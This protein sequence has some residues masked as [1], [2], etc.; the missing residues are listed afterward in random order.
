RSGRSDGAPRPAPGRSLPGG[1]GRGLPGSPPRARRPGSPGSPP[2][3]AAPGSAPPPRSPERPSAAARPPVPEPAS[4]RRC[5]YQLLAAA[6]AEVDHALIGQAA[7][8]GHDLLLRRLD[9]GQAYRAAGLHVLQQ[10]LGRTLGHVAGDLLAHPD[11]GAAQGDA[12]ALAGDLAQQGLQLA[13][14]QLDQVVEHEH[15]V[16][17]AL[18]QF[19]V[20]LAD[21]AQDRLVLP[22]LQEVEDV[23]RDLDA[24]D[25]G[26]LEVLVAG[27]LALH[28]LVE[29]V[30]RVRR[31]AVEG[32]D[33]Q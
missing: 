15:Q 9:V 23:R 6:V 7:D 20:D 2:G 13:V 5:S 30:Q 8:D 3:W 32:G 16:L 33:A 28:D 1:P 24:A 4:G 27:E 22:G 12:Q 18:A 31:D 14:V 19:A 11:V 29:L 17:D 26:R 21:L 25:V 10:D